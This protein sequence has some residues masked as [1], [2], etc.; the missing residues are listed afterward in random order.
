VTFAKAIILAATFAVLASAAC[1]SGS[2]SSPD[3]GFGYSGTGGQ[4]VSANFGFDLLPDV[5]VQIGSNPTRLF[6]VDTGA[7]AVILDSNI[8]TDHAAGVHT[9]ETL[10]AFNLTFSDV[11]ELSIPISGDD[12][13]GLI[14]GDLLRHFAYTLDYVGNRAWLSD[15]F[16]TS[17]IPA[18]V[19]AGTE[20]DIPFALLG[21]GNFIAFTGCTGSS[22]NVTLPPTRV[23][24]QATFED[25][26]TPVW[27]LVDSGSSLVVIDP[28]VFDALDPDVGRRPTIEGATLSTVTGANDAFY[29][30]VWRVNVNGS[31]GTASTISADNIVAA[32]IPG[33]N[34]LATLANETGKPVKA[35][36]GGAFFRYFLTTVDYQTSKLRL[37][38]Y[39]DPQIDPTDWVGPGFS[40]NLNDKSAVE[41]YTNK[42]AAAQGLQNGDTILQIGS[43]SLAGASDSAIVNAYLSY[44]LGQP[45][46]VTFSHGGVM[47]TVN[48][49]V[50]NLLPDYPP[51][52]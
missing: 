29:T 43:L 18:D 17:D 16:K 8:Y 34:L 7:P 52:S 5:Q 37:Q 13:A 32:V 51:P 46:P 42:D 3:A 24:V 30:R 50:E 35:L 41:V 19:A 1:S 40:I 23:L 22:C 26:T 15:P 10:T 20:E 44:T 49:M 4:P 31:N 12:P 2:S 47:H 48:V 25:A 28:A 21:G 9:G 11:T 14:G 38:R 45:M 39:D 33:D 27:V 36:L 6:T